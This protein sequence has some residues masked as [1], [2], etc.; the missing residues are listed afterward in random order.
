[1]IKT[2]ERNITGFI[3]KVHYAYFGVKLG[4]QDKSYTHTLC[5]KGTVEQ[6]V[7][8]GSKTVDTKDIT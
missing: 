6:E 4:D 2:H 7:N 3:I 8:T 1:M 5:V